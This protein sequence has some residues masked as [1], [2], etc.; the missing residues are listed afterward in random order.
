MTW[1]SS[2]QW[3]QIQEL[4]IEKPMISDAIFRSFLFYRHMRS[5]SKFWRV[6]RSNKN[7]EHH[8]PSTNSTLTGEHL[9]SS[10]G[11]GKLVLVSL[12]S[13]SSIVDL[14]L[15]SRR[16]DRPEMCALATSAIIRRISWGR[17]LEWWIGWRN[18]LRIPNLLQVSGMFLDASVTRFLS[19]YNRW[20]VN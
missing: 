11:L 16:D 1:Q 2:Q 13:R 10:W 4:I 9:P 12:N 15:A 18:K 19:S 6:L 7:I 5:N 8:L 20:T 17:K 14:M 3:S